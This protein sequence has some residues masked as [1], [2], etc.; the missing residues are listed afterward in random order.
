MVRNDFRQRDEIII[1]T[2]V[3]MTELC[4]SALPMFFLV[5]VTIHQEM[6]YSTVI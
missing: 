3:N 1:A 5:N 2:R 4:V 6:L